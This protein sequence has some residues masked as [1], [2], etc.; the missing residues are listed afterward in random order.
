MSK[1]HTIKA[2]GFAPLK[3]SVFVSDLDHG[4]QKTMGG[5]ILPD[6]NMTE[7]GIHARWGKVFAIGPEV[8][9]LRV[10]D[11]VLTAHGR[12]TPGIDLELN[13]TLTR[14]WR[15]EY[16]DSVLLASHMDLRTRHKTSL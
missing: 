7:R 10:G 16:P 4:A 3:N 11:W 1:H 8:D 2:A 6:D 12:W 5:I 14:V 15:V 13:G 9:D